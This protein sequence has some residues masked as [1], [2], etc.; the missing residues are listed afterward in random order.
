MDKL[1]LI[2]RELAFIDR[3]S[4]HIDADSVE[5]FDRADAIGRA[6]QS[7]LLALTEYRLSL[8]PEVEDEFPSEIAA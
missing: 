4:Q 8:E 6:V 5:N 2:E 7:A 3:Q 1:K